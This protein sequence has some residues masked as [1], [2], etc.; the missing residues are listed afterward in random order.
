MNYFEPYTRS[1]NKRKVE[2]DLPNFA[3]RL[4]LEKCHRCSYNRLC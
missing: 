4:D 3:T 2:L 1:K